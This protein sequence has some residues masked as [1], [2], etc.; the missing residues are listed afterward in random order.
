LK[1]LGR[2]FV[3]MF[4]LFSFP[5]QA[6]ASIPDFLDE[7]FDEMMV[8]YSAYRRP[9][10]EALFSAHGLDSSNQGNKGDFFRIYFLHDLLTTDNASNC[11]RGGFLRIP[12]F[13][14]WVEPNPRH[15]IISLPDSVPLTSVRTRPPYGNYASVADIDRLPALFLGDL[16]A[17]EPGFYHPDCGSFFT[18][19][20]CSEREM[21][22]TAL[23][24]SWG[25]KSKIWQSGIHTY[26]VVWCEFKTTSGSTKTLAAEVDNTFGSITWREVPDSK[27]LNQWLEETGNGAQIDW[28]NNQARSQEQLEALRAKHV[29]Q[30]AISRFRK[31][32]QGALS[33]GR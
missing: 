29:T 6:S 17:E 11:A 3:T 8:E 21:S 4:L 30:G 1:F 5:V 26:S 23:M 12:Y 10:F 2:L 9:E 27:S 32:I 14:H 24:T 28:Y 33:G 16:V 25:L 31:L 19:G 18:F 15:S 22:Y 20:W 13:W 7:L